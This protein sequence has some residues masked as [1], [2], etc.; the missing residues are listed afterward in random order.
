MTWWKVSIHA[1]AEHA[2]ALAFLI[3]EEA[4]TAVEITDLTTMSKSEEASVSVLVIGLDSPPTEGF[5]ATVATW[6]GR[7]DI[8][9]TNVKIER[10]DDEGWRER[11]KEFFRG[12]PLSARVWVRPP[13]EETDPKAPFT[14]VIEPGMAFG[15][16]HHETTRG[17]LIV[18]DTLLA[19]HHADRV[20]DLGC[21]S[22]IL[23]IGAA[24]LGSQAVG[25]EIDPE[26]LVNARENVTHNGVE[27]RVTLLEGS[28]DVTDE[29]FPIVLANIIARTLTELAAPIMQRCSRDL[30]LAGLLHAD[31]DSVL[32]AYEAFELVSRQPDG[33]WCVLHLRRPVAP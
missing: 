15:T 8:A 18:L 25:V 20:L 11:W 29:V 12:G 19:E 32:V 31:I 33:E 6:M 28:V 26:A 4:H 14:I 22:A 21:G 30:V 27:D 10:T 2:E 17:V 3:A 24:L 16:G 1:P 5:R 9:S 7:F 23:A 13:W